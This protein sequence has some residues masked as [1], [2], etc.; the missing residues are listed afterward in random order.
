MN[1]S[2]RNIALLFLLA[3][4]SISVSSIAQHDKKK[5]RIECLKSQKVAFLTE[6]VG[7]SSKEGQK[8]WPVYNEFSGRMD[9]LWSIKKEN[10]DELYDSKNKMTNAQK[11]A[12]IDLHIE[13]ELKKAELEKK[14][15]RK[16]KSILSIDKVIKLYGAEHEFKKKMLH[17]I[18]DGKP[19]SCG[20]CNQLPDDELSKT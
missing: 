7:L 17:M 14:Y 9:S 11:E 10:L 5:D 6:R 19:S 18:R 1:Y 2:V 3:L 15:H 13:L 20:D 12:A 4:Q 8:F 16:F